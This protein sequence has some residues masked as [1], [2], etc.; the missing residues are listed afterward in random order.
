MT[1]EELNNAGQDGLGKFSQLTD[2]WMT[3]D[4]PSGNIKSTENTMDILFV[5]SKLPDVEY[6]YIKGGLNE[7]LSM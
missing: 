4:F 7:V 5:A 1:D 3:N 2:G 6:G